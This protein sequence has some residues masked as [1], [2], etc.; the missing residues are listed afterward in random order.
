MILT[1]S[2]NSTLIECLNIEDCEGHSKNHC[3]QLCKS[4]LQLWKLSGKDTCKINLGFLA[5][6]REIKTS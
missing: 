2:E 6:L 5:V 1:Y 3:Q 4:M